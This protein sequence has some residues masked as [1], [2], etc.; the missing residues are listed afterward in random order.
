[1]KKLLIM[2][3]LCAGTVFLYAQTEKKFN[4][5]A[6]MQPVEV[7]SIR[8]PGNAPFAKTDL[9]KKD[10][11]IINLVQD[12]PFLLNQTPSVVVNSDAGNGVGYTGIRIRGSDA[13]RINVTL[14]GIPYNDAESLGTFFVDLP[15]IA[16]SASSIQVQR[17]VGSSSNGAG[18]FGATINIA[19]N[20]VNS[21]PYISLNNAYGSFN[22]WKNNIIFGSGI[23]SHHFITEGRLSLIRT[24]GYIDRAKSYLKSAYFSTAYLDEKNSLR[25]NIFSGKEKTY[26]AWNGVPGYL[27]DSLRTYNSSGTEKPGAPYENETDNYLQT[28]YQLFYNRRYNNYL[29]GNISLFYTKGRGYYEEYRAS[30]SLTDYGLPDYISGAAIITQTDMVKR[31]WL[32]NDLY[33]MIFS[34]QYLQKN[35]Q[36]IAGGGWNDYDGRHYGELTWAAVQAAVPL[37]Y[38]WYDLK[39]NKKDLSFYLK[40]IQQLSAHWQSFSD[41][42]FRNVAYQ[43]NGFSHNPSLQIG[44]NYTFFNP[45]LGITYTNKGWKA[46]VSC[47]IAAKEPIRDDFEAGQAQQPVP[48]KLFDLEAGIEK[49]GTNYSYFA[50]CYFMNY[51]NQLVLTGKIND[52]GAYTRTNI[53]DSYRSGIEL[54]GN[55]IFSSRLNISGNLSLSENRIRKFTEYVDDYD[56][57][58]QQSKYYPKTDISFSPAVV[59]G[60]TINFIP[61]KKGLVSLL[62]KY[63]SRQYLDNTSQRSRSLNPYFL[64][65]IRFSYGL[66]NKSFKSISVTLQLNNVFNRKYEPNGYSFSYVTGGKLNT[67]NFYFPMAG[68][69]FMA[70]INLSF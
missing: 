68:F 14:N 41:L 22:T 51:H 46:Y 25:L 27:L 70:G 40:W 61:V 13:T 69:N 47:S 9:V 52:V 15:D 4:D 36:F 65:D 66:V 21:N 59:A 49:K 2:G 64:E 62:S 37:H 29:K 38:H 17:G 31:L 10:I 34:L 3:C 43:I 28:H 45:K 54:L 53:P 7:Q 6:L 39:A 11:E 19:T 26:Q 23:L 8:A 42:Q 33:G 57:G 44:K 56:N 58:G 32:D 55:M 5:T 67:E 48:E 1:M 16:S 20:E 24:S 12:L 63:V 60:S 35:T 30:Q 50:G 18:A